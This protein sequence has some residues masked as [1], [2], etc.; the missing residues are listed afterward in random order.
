MC[1]MMLTMKFKG[2]L[3]TVSCPHQK[4]RLCSFC[5]GQL[6]AVR[7]RNSPICFMALTMWQAWV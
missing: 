4:E 2:L 5:A 7:M 3:P 6:I 1:F